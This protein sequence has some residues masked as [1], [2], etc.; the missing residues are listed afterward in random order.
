MIGILRG[1]ETDSSVMSVMIR[2]CS[3][4]I[5]LSSMAFG[6]TVRLFIFEGSRMSPITKRNVSYDRKITTEIP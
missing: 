2:K 6:L 1:C 5:C 3:S 4:S